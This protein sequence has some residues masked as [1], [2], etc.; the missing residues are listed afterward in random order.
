MITDKVDKLLKHPSKKYGKRNI[1]QIDGFVIHHSATSTG[2]SESF[3]NY[4]VNNRDWPGI[5]YHYVVDKKGNIDLTNNI[6]TISYHTSGQNTKKIGICMIGNFNNEIPTTDQINAVRYLIHSISKKFP[7]IHKVNLHRDYANT[8]CAGSNVNIDMFVPKIAG[9]YDVP[10]IKLQEC[11]DGKFTTS[12]GRGACK[13]HKGILKDIDKITEDQLLQNFPIEYP[14]ALHL[15]KNKIKTSSF[16]QFGDRNF[17]NE[18]FM[19]LSDNGEPLDLMEL[20][21]QNDNP[22]VTIQDIIDFIRKYNNPYGAI[23]EMKTILADEENE[24]V[25]QEFLQR[26]YL[27]DIDDESETTDYDIEEVPF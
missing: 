11:K 20:E 19:F 12:T 27:F 7:N 10:Y 17:V 3:A 14:I 13:G 24:K 18:V 16:Y 5:G 15:T 1:S 9:I 21:I 25:K 6:N 2:S 23:Y 22:N 8:S 4:H 26:N